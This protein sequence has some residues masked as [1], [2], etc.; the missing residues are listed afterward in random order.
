MSRTEKLLDTVLESCQKIN[1][2]EFAPPGIFT[3][4]IITKP[5]VTS[6]IRDALVPEPSLYRITKKAAEGSQSYG[7]NGFFEPKPT[8]IDGSSIYVAPDFQ[9]WNDAAV[10]VPKLV[11]EPSSDIESTT[12]ESSSPSKKRNANI[13]RLIPQAVAESEDFNSI[14]NTVRQVAD[15]YADTE[16][17]NGIRG[18]V[19][20]LQA[21][22]N[23][24]LHETDEL[25]NVVAEQ[26]KQLEIYN[27]SLNELSPRRGNISPQRSNGIDEMIEREEQE[28]R[29]LEEELNKR[30]V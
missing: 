13:L 16:G 26:R 17:A 24:L 19:D 18:K 28:I 29:I 23:D 27:D 2:L 14:C 12:L 20:S 15:Q 1:T 5:E 30:Q 22:Y 11:S 6:L 21:E 25:E 8:R 4:A 9:D 3:N 7:E 10:K